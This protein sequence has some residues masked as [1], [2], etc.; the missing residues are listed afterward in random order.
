MI[1][2]SSKRLK[3]SYDWR[4]MPVEFTRNDACID[5]HEQIVCGSMKLVMAYDGEGRVIVS[6]SLDSTGKL[7]TRSVNELDARG[8]VVKSHP[9]VS[10]G[11]TPRPANCVIPNEYWYDAQ[12]RVVRSVEPDAGETRTFYDL[13]GRVRA[14][15]TQRQIDSGAYSVTVYDNLDR[16]IYTGEWKS[17]LDSGAARAYFGNVQNRNSPTVAGL[18]PGTV[19]RMFYDRMPARDTLGVELYPATVQADAF[20]YGR[21]RTVAVISDVSADGGGNVTRVSTANTYDKYGRVLATYTFDPTMP[22]DSLKMLAVETE[23]DL[24]GKV[25]RTTKYPYGVDGGGAGRKIV[26]RY[27]YDRLG[28]IDSL[29]SKNGGGDEVLLAHFTYYPTGSVKTVNMGNSLTLTYTYHISGAVKT[30]AVQSADGNTLYSETLYYEDCGNNACT[31]QYNGNISRM[32]HELAHGNADFGQYRDVAYAYDQL[33]RLTSADDVEQDYFDEVFEYDAQGRMTVQRRDTSIAKNAGGEYAY[34]ANT[35]RLKSIANGMGGT[36]D[37]RITSDASNFV[38]DSEGNLIEDKSKK[39]KIFYDWRGMPVEFVREADGGDSLKLVMAYDGSGKRISKTRLRKIAN[40][41]E[42]SDELTTHYTG[43]GTEIRTNNSDG[44]TKVVINMPQGLGRYAIEYADVNDSANAGF[45][46]YLKNHLGS[47]MAVYRTTGTTAG[48]PML[49][50]AYDYRSYGEKI[51]L[52]V[53]TDKVT[54]NYTGKELDDETELGYWGVRYLD[55]ML[56]MWISVDQKKQFASLYLYSG[57]GFNPVNFVDFEGNEIILSQDQKKLLNYINQA[58]YEQYNVNEFGRLVSADICNEQG[59]VYYSE[60]LNAGINSV[61]KL[62]LVLDENPSN[63]YSAYGEG[64]TIP[65]STGVN[66]AISIISGKAYL[67]SSPAQNLLHEM[68]SHGIPYIL[69]DR[70]PNGSALVEE[71]RAL[72]NTSFPLPEGV[73]DHKIGD[74]L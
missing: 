71:I 73:P 63:D 9:P 64:V 24:G 61:N 16:A 59:S 1:A 67:N 8:N 62:F 15:Q 29:F 46:W 18:T 27:T 33:N 55:L 19:T 52:T 43:I 12:S 41:T 13:M 36:A 10:C 17:S 66:D 37:D 70:N 68:V 40:A 21:T 28:R 65:S 23:Y 4:G 35:N 42:W 34:Y 32:A 7:L 30:A 58:S 5:I 2:D 60:R 26:E 31:P 51:D 49:Q 39:M 11:Y 14:T 74:E 25:T 20:R 47:T 54:E 45:E 38:Y 22:A 56:G 50:H 53:L 57:N 48:P 44:E 69:Q 72:E 6:G 3:I